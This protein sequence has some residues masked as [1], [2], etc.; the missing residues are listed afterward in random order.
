MHACVNVY[1]WWCIRMHV[2]DHVMQSQMISSGVYHI[3]YNGTY[4]V[5]GWVCIDGYVY[6]YMYMI[7]VHTVVHSGLVHPGTGRG[8]THDHRGT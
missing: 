4:G 8:T 2:H 3:T 7:M 6:A 5:H 1:S